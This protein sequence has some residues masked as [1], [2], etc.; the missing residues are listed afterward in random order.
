MWCEQ[1]GLSRRPPSGVSRLS[2]GPAL[3]LPR[4]PITL[5]GAAAAREMHTQ[6]PIDFPACSKVG[7]ATRVLAPCLPLHCPEACPEAPVPRT[8]FWAAGPPFQEPRTPLRPR[9]ALGGPHIPA[10]HGQPGTAVLALSAAPPDELLSGAN[11]AAAAAAAAGSS[12]THTHATFLCSAE[13]GPLICACP[14]LDDEGAGSVRN[15]CHLAPFGGGQ[16][17]VLDTGLR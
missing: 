16:D 6:R 3:S 11:T 9:I 7:L 17:A 13:A 5:S 14:G 12:I 10:Q 2:W 1:V 4:L 15:K 8:T